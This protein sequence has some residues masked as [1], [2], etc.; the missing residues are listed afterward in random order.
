[1]K[2]IISTLAILLIAT[3]VYAQDFVTINPNPRTSGMGNAT[4]AVSGDAIFDIRQC[5]RP[6]VRIPQRTGAGIIHA[7]AERCSQRLLSVVA[8]RIRQDRP[9]ARSFNRRALVP[10]A[11]LAGLEA[12]M[13]GYPF[14]PKDEEGNIISLDITRPNGKSLV[15]A[16]AY[17][18]W[19]ASRSRGHGPIPALLQRHRRQVRRRRFRHCGILVDTALLLEGSSLR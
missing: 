18:V 17:K 15:W 6:A 14:I 9:E 5:S 11:K 12:G 13:D 1:M 10:G 2:K 8:R 7:M 3:G 16:Y 19:R 4:V